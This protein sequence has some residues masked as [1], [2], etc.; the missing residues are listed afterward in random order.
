MAMARLR[1]H[2]T[3]RPGKVFRERE[4]MD[5]N[6]RSENSKPFSIN[7]RRHWRENC[8][9]A[10]EELMTRFILSAGLL[11][12]ALLA[13]GCATKK[14]VQ[15]TAAPIQTK[16][17]Q[18]G[19]Q[20]TQNTQQIQQTRTDLTANINGVDEKAQSGIS[21]AKEQ[22]MTA[23]N[24][25]QNAMNKANG[26]SSLANQDSEEIKSLRQVVSNLDDYKPVGDLTIPFAFNKFTLTDKDRTD[27]DSMVD[28]ASKNKRYFIAVE[29]FTDSTG[30]R[31]YNE[32]LS[33][34]R[35][36][37]VTEYLV[38]KH[39]IPIYRI[40]M[41]GLGQE[42]PVDDGHTRAARAKN[43]RVEIKVFSA[44]ESY[45]LSQSQAASPQQAQTQ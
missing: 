22:A 4:E 44:D 32:S 39:D 10:G 31:E 15:E 16:V 24:S 28:N 38:A 25:A 6:S 11:G 37:A 23:Q 7:K 29:G 1:F 17:D 41:I 9:M 45:A 36:D 5:E 42:K 13:G 34:K 18:V 3:P 35:A 40:H 12:A 14:Y 27:L 30:S 33:R 20:T 2:N 8:Y 26:A 21:A 43:R 19:N